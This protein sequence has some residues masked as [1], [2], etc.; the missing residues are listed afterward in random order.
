LRYNRLLGQQGDGE[1]HLTSGYF[2][3]ST[4]EDFDG[5]LPRMYTLGEQGL[6]P[7]IK[8]ITAFAWL[9][10]LAIV[11]LFIAGFDLRESMPR[12]A[13]LMMICAVV[14]FIERVLWSWYLFDLRDQQPPKAS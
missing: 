13:V 2:G 14:V 6:V 4:K 3:D 12:V 1:T 11:L 7:M 9:R 8:S 10:D 5:P